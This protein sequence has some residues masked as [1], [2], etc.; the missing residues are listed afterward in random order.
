VWADFVFPILFTPFF[1]SILFSFSL[2]LSILFQLKLN[3]KYKFKIARLNAQAIKLQ[4]ECHA[5]F[6]LLSYSLKQMLLNMESIHKNSCSR[7]IIS[8]VNSF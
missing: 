1:F 8:S 6:Y 7:K 5:Y 2:F 3:F 4:Y